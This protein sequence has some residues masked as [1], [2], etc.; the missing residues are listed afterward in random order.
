MGTKREEHHQLRSFVACSLTC[1]RSIRLAFTP[2]EA[3]LLVVAC[4]AALWIMHVPYAF[5]AL[6]E[7]GKSAD[8]CFRMNGCWRAAE[9]LNRSD[10]L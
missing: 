8:V 7:A 5:H 4:P 1:S 10:G 2:Q 6:D 9:A 3:P